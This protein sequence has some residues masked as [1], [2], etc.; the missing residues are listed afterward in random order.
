MQYT[1]IV[2]KPKTGDSVR[3]LIQAI[4]S[5]LGWN[6]VNEAFLVGAGNLGTALL[7]HG[8]F[9]H[10][11]LRIV[12]AFDTEAHQDPSL[13]IES[14]LL[15]NIVQRSAN[16]L[17]TRYRKRTAIQCLRTKWF[18]AEAHGELCGSSLTEQGGRRKITCEGIHA[19]FMQFREET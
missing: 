1:G 9:S 11:G 12:A 5:F 6:K 3:G 14:G 16:V 2:G 15:R 4:E 19:V 17:E 18:C 8:R 13:P 10:F 7:G